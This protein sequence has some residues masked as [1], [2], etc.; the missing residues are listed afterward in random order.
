MVPCIP[1]TLCKCFRL[2]DGEDAGTSL[3]PETDGPVGPEG[4]GEHPRAFA[5]ACGNR[6]AEGDLTMALD[7]E[8]DAAETGVAA[9][10]AGPLST[11]GDREETAIGSGVKLWEPLMG[12]RREPCCGEGLATC[13][14]RREPADN[15]GELARSM[16]PPPEKMPPKESG[17]V[18]A[19]NPQVPLWGPNS[20]RAGENGT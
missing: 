19:K 3:A 2:D 20:R 4:V 18:R 11:L 17:S 9:K 14:A 10:G 1:G 7:D 5:A 8:K 13:G 16:G 12:T 6:P 15:A